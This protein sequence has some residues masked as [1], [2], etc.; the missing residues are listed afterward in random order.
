M[1]THVSTPADD[2][3]S[4]AAGD[5]VAYS[6]NSGGYAFDL[7]AGA[8]Q[9]TDT[10]PSNGSDG[11]DTVSGPRKLSFTDGDVDFALTNGEFRVNTTTANDQQFAGVATLA[12]GSFVV[13]WESSDQD[14]SGRGIYAQRFD[15]VGSRVGSEFQVNKTVAGD[16][17]QPSVTALADGGFVV[18]WTAGEQHGGPYYDVHGQRFD[19][20][21]TEQ[22]IE[23]VVN[24]YTTYNQFS[25]SVAALDDGG[26]VVTWTSYDATRG[27]GAWGQLFDASGVPVGGEFLVTATSNS[28][29]HVP[30]W[31]AVDSS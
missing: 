4:G 16:Q 2:T 1:T 31:L 3:I 10:D 23:F 12:D 8:L 26:F 30:H 20:T 6:G 24:T 19:A 5:V 18:T 14:G 22:G 11:T 21:G 7:S 13:V 29:G 28:W 25:S 17:F 15:A 9:V 27:D